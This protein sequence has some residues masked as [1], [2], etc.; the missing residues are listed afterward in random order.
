MESNYKLTIVFLLAVVF[1]TCKETPV[2]VVETVE[3]VDKHRS[4]YHFTPDSMWM[5]DPNGMFFHDG[6]YHLFYQY[7]PD[8]TVWGP[9]HWGHATSKDMISWDHKDIAIYPDSLG[10]IFSGSAVVDINNTSGF[11]KNGETPIVAIFTHH[12]QP[13][14]SAGRIDY[15][16]Q[17]IAYSLDG[18]D[19]FI[20]Y[21]GNPV[22][23]NPGIKDFRD[24]KVFWHQ[25]TNKW[26]MILAA[27]NKIMIFN[28]DNLKEWVYKSEFGQDIGAHGGVWECPDLFELPVEGSD[29]KKWV[30]LLS[31]NPGAPNGGS[32]TQ[33]FVGDFDGTTFVM[34]DAFGAQIKSDTAIWIDYGRDNYAGVTWSNIP[35]SDGRRLFMGWMSNWNYGQVVPTER[36]RSAMTLARTLHLTKNK[37]AYLLTSKPVKE[38][39]MYKNKKEDIQKVSLEQPYTVFEQNPNGYFELSG[40]STGD[41][42]IKFLSESDEDLTLTI[43][44]NQYILNRIKS[45][46]LDFLSDNFNG[47]QFAPRYSD[48]GKFS[49]T[50]FIDQSSVEIFADEGKTVLTSTYF[51]DKPVSKVVIEGSGASLENGSWGFI[52]LN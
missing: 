23:N 24:P 43:T 4:H 21:E 29:D 36:W 38:L 40:I 15:Q 44:N 50:V 10:W 42:T 26:V 35:E 8:S 16:Y 9:M 48:D 25:P 7:Y 51:F 2:S 37:E 32:G 47:K 52:R 49:L 46:K 34:D 45:S 33:Y 6:V 22:L 17:S 20:K 19:T 3:T 28:S 11:A 12:S 31:I 39:D 1:W 41:V 5:N 13:K 14:E 18:G 30:M 27:Q